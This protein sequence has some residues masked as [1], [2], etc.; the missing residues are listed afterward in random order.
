MKAEKDLRTFELALLAGMRAA[1]YVTEALRELAAGEADLRAAR[2]RL[3]E[4]GFHTP[5]HLAELYRAILGPP[6]SVELDDLPPESPFAG[7]RSLRFQLPLWPEHD[8]VVH[9]HPSGYAWGN[10]FRAGAE[11]ARPPRSAADLAPWGFTKEEIEAQLGPGRVE[12][13]WGDFADIVYRIPPTP[14]ASPREYLLAFDFG[15]L[16]VVQPA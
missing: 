16:Q 13:A 11:R 9:E 15:L 3:W 7:S 10:G 8:F 2:E 1:S 5:G 4:I 14:G 6:H 12:D